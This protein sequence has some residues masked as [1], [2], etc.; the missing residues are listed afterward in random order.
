MLAHQRGT[1]MLCSSGYVSE[2]DAGLCTGCGTC[3]EMC[4]FAAVSLQDGL[5]TVDR[6]ACMGC[7]VCV[8]QCPQGALSL[9]RAPDKGEPLVIR[10]LA[11][12]AAE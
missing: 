7:G 1:P 6:A 8:S 4:P 11:G 5:A 12:R 10:E 3:A 2:V 9:V